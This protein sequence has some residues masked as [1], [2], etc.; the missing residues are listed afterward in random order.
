MAP[1]LITPALQTLSAQHVEQLKRRVCGTLSYIVNTN[2]NTTYFRNAPLLSRYRTELRLDPALAQGTSAPEVDLNTFTGSVPLSTYEDYRSYISRFMENPCLQSSVDSLLAPGL[3]TFIATSSGTSGSSAKY[4]PKYAHPRNIDQALVTSMVAGVPEVDGP[5]R[6]IVFSL[7]Y[8]HILDVLDGQEVVKKI[9]FSLGTAGTFRNQNGWE[10]ENDKEFVQTRLSGHVTPIA[11]AFIKPYYTFLLLHALFAM[12]ERSLT[13]FNTI[14]IT[15]F[16]DLV[17]LIEAHWEDLVRAI[18]TGQIPDLEGLDDL[19]SHI[20]AHLR[21]RPDRAEEL[22]KIGVNAGAIGWLKQMWPNLTLVA[23]NATGSFSTVLPRVQNHVGPSVS[24]Q[25]IAY[26]SSEAWVGIIYNPESGDNL[27]KA[28]TTGDVIEY[29]DV[30]QPESAEYIIQ[31]WD[32][33]VGKKYEVILTTRDGFWRYRLGDVLEIKG[34]APEDGS[35]LIRFLERR[36]AVMRISGEF[37]SEAE[38]HRAVGSIEDIIGRVMEFSVVVDDRWFPRRYGFLLEL[39]S[40]PGPHA[41]TAPRRLQEYLSSTNSTFARFNSDSK[42]GKP[43]VRV[44]AAGHSADTGRGGSG[45]LG[46]GAGR[47]RFRRS[48]MTPRRGIGLLGMWCESWGMN[49]G[50]GMKFVFSPKHRRKE[51]RVCCSYPHSSRTIE[52]LSLRPGV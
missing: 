19:R 15:V 14:F 16:S 18:E 20:Q 13:T 6:C 43:S 29:L 23:G 28:Q 3:P 45:S 30:E 2:S 35:P 5:T 44:L 47:R 40:E 52:R 32:L 39:E 24:I 17:R 11:V 31:A 37:V 9:P 25:S 46:A 41:H 10:I 51:C 36:S 26:V 33:K 48:F 34:F 42:V 50:G 21:P 1:S 4:F 38:L 22:R 12:G 27:Y 7:R 49:C 8:T